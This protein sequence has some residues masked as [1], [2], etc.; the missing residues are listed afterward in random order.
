MWPD[1]LAVLGLGTLGGSLAWQA[2]QAGVAR[3]IGYS[4]TPAD[5]SQA[6][7]AGAI[8]DRAESVARACRGARLVAVTGGPAAVIRWLSELAPHL[9]PGAIVTDLAPVRR[10]VQESVG[11]LGLSVRHAGSCPVVVAHG[12]GFHGAAPALFRGAMVYICPSSPDDSGARGVARFWSDVLEAQPV[13]VSAGTIDE[14][15]AWRMQLPV[16]VA[17]AIARA[18]VGSGSVTPG[19]AVG[20]PRE[21]STLQAELLLANRDEV[22]RALEGVEENLAAL[23]A[24]IAGGDRAGLQT[25]LDMNAGVPG[26]G[27]R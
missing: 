4:A 2:R 20:G 5:A 21:E 12:S 23:Q 7:R 19:S 3:V 8:S 15:T 25:L 13:T 18:Q 11:E 1:S 27:A 9:E 10:I 24:L 6:L 14:R 16:L 26:H 17:A 22:L